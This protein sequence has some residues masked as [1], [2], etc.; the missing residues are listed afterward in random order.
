MC[1]PPPNV[2]KNAIICEEARLNPDAATFVTSN[3]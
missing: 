3:D 2:I 1:G